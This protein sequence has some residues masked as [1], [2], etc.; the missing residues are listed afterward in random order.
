MEKLFDDLGNTSA[1]T[2]GLLL[3]R[4]PDLSSNMPSDRAAEARIVG[5]MRWIRTIRIAVRI[6]LDARFEE[7]AKQAK[8][9]QEKADPNARSW[10]FQSVAGERNSVYYVF[11]LRNS[12]AGF[13]AGNLELQRIMGND[14]FQSF[15]KTASEIVQTEETTLSQFVPALSNP[16]A[17]IAAAAP[18]YWMPKPAAPKPAAAKPAAGKAPATQ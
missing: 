14:A 18:D 11:Q 16:T 3:R 2:R 15:L 10:I 8:A 9:A 12:L 5:T 1:G 7:L 4:R 13:D 6:G 17:D